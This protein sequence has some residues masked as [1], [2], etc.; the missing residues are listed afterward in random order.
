MYNKLNSGGKIILEIDTH[1]RILK[2]M[3]NHKLNVWQEFREPDPWR[4]A[5]WECTNDQDKNYITLKKTFIKRD[6]G[7]LS[8]SEVILKNYSKSNI[9]SLLSE[10]G[11]K[12]VQTFDDW[13]TKGDTI[14]D[15]YIVV[16]EK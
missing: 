3:E 5:L 6:L 13:D 11:F 12:N 15:E 9:A 8:E 2:R 16:A 7:N 1:K 4:F 14:D 10:I